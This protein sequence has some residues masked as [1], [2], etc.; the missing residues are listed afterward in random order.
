M[1]TIA[2]RGVRH[3]GSFLYGRA[4]P[5]KSFKSVHGSQ[6]VDTAP[7]GATVPTGYPQNQ[8]SVSSLAL[9]RSLPSMFD[10]SV[11]Y[12]LFDNLVPQRP[13]SIVHR[14]YSTLPIYC[15]FHPVTKCYRFGWEMEWLGVTV[16]LCVLY[17]FAG[18]YQ[19][20]NAFGR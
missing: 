5:A 8:R 14:S 7:V 18:L 6:R 13:G 9:G 15:Q 20:S 4:Y 12:S 1:E 10:W 19:A 11:L 2:Q 17:Q 3:G 16:E